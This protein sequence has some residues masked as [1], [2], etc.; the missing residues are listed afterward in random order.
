MNFERPE[1]K[2]VIAQGNKYY[3]IPDAISVYAP[4]SKWNGEGAKMYIETNSVR[5]AY[6]DEPTISELIQKIKPPELS[7]FDKMLKGIMDVPKPKN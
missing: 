1:I 2:S 7:N 4:G 5:E 3:S 6:S